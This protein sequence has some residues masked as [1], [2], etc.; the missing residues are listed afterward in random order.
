MAIAT[1]EGSNGEIE[2]EKILGT[3]DGTDVIVN[4]KQFT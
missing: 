1:R 2:W 3:F 4:G